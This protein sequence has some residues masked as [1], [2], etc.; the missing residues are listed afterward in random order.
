M[1]DAELQRDFGRMEAEIKNLRKDVAD[2]VVDVKALRTAL[3]EIKG[4]TRT[5]LG[6]ASLIGGLI[7]LAG[8]YLLGKHG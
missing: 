1:S 7:A 6:I 8:Q 2:L 5:L 3:S 4:G